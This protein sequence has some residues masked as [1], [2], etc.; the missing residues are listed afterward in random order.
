MHPLCVW[1]FIKQMRISHCIPAYFLHKCSKHCKNCSAPFFHLPC[2]RDRSVSMHGDI[3]CSVFVTVCIPSQRRTVVCWASQP[4][5]TGIVAF[6]ITKSTTVS[7]SGVCPRVLL[8]ASLSGILSSI[9]CFLL[10]LITAKPWW[11]FL[12]TLLFLLFCLCCSHPILDSSC[13][14][15]DYSNS[16]GIP[17]HFSPQSSL[18]CGPWPDSFP[19]ILLS[20]WSLLTPLKNLW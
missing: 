4:L 7:S 1:I 3:P 19:E 17:I 13:R 11:S 12:C 9:C 8:A 16:R 20:P 14:C 15:L 6:A 2:P 5:L 10:Y 18:C